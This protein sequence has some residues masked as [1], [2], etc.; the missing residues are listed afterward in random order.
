MAASKKSAPKNDDTKQQAAAEAPDSTEEKAEGQ[1]TPET[2][3]TE[4]PLPIR[5][6]PGL[7]VAFIQI[8]FLV[9]V[10]SPSYD[11]FT[12]F[13]LMMGGP[14]LIL[15]LMLTWQVLLSRATFREVMWNWFL[16]PLIALGIVM[17]TDSTARITF[18]FYGV[19]AFMV[20]IATLSWFMAKASPWPRIGVTTTLTLLAWAVFPFL[21]ING[22]EGS[23]YP[24]FAYRW[25]EVKMDLATEGLVREKVTKQP[26]ELIT[27]STDWPAFRGPKRNSRA[28][29]PEI[30]LDWE[31]KPPKELWNVEIGP[32][33]SSCTIVG[34]LLYTQQQRGE[35]EGV[36]AYQVSDGQEYWRHFDASRF[37]EIVSGPGPRAT[38]TYAVINNEPVLF[39]TGANGLLTCLHA[40]TGEKVWQRDLM[41]DYD[42]RLPIWGFSGS[43]LVVNNLVIVYV[44][45]EDPQ[46]VAAAEAKQKQADE[47][48]EDEEQKKTTE[49]E[50]EIPRI[51]WAAFSA[52]DGK[53][54]W[55]LD[56]TG[57]N[58]TSAQLEQIDGVPQLLLLS[59][60]GLMGVDPAQGE[61]LWTYAPENWPEVAYVQPQV[62]SGNQIIVPMGDGLESASIEVK[63]SKS[64]N[65]TT[66]ELWRR[67][68]LKPSFND[69]VYFDGH[70]YG[71]DQNIFAC[72]DVKT[73]DRIWK[74]GRYGFGQVMLLE[75]QGVLLITSEKGEL[76]ALKA[77]PTAHEELARLKVVDGKTWNHP[78]ISGSRLFIRNGASLVCLKLPVVE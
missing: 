78:A 51:G 3:T 36:V 50:P 56:T 24:E 58:Y 45:G 65:W 75:P 52:T 62:I 47:Q 41:A 44:D 64:E 43:P 21:K 17:L 6:W 61:T 20:L 12:R 28:L 42:A 8:V 70:L 22:F 40:L 16:M 71:F 5:A 66:K 38:P 53:L 29:S 4:E 13:V 68:T 32:G 60:K 63:G 67:N 73:G 33:W 31:T 54:A 18:L 9:V 72:V 59:N 11:N 14:V 35:L 30:S 55:S 77:N 1:T 48:T 26:A 7:I 39:V 19:P 57:M 49:E 74:K 37:K 25:T 27:S 15:I 69:F 76:V 23:Y 2:E 10:I 34:D 46:V